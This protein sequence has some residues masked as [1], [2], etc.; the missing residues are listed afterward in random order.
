MRDRYP[1]KSGEIREGGM[2]EGGLENKSNVVSCP[3]PVSKMSW[4]G[5]EEGPPF[6]FSRKEDPYIP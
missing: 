1:K 3:V 2:E 5:N 6:L 4:E